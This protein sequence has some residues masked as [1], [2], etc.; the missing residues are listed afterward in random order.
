MILVSSHGCEWAARNVA[1]HLEPLGA[2]NVNSPAPCDLRVLVGYYFRNNEG[3][4]RA[5]ILSA[6]KAVV[7]WVGT[8]ILWLEEDCGRARRE[9]VAWLNAH[10]AEHW[11]EWDVSAERLKRAGLQRVRIVAMPTRNL[12]EPMPL[13]A[14]FTAGVYCYDSRAAFYGWPA[15]EKA[16][17]L[18]PDID[19]IVY[20]RNKPGRAARNVEFVGRVDQDRMGELYARMSVHVRIVHADGMPQGPMEAAMCGRP[21]VYNFR[22]MPH[23]R[24]LRPANGEG[25]ANLLREIRAEQERGNGYNLE[26]SRFWRECNDP[27]KLRREIRRAQGG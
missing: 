2:K 8:D 23:V 21:V 24:L 14:R 5:E 20:P 3:V 7:W 4:Q 12:Y 17:A 22:P 1:R 11:A 15:V 19:W 26:G 10:A 13:P 16:I 27:E 9:R 6:R 25:L 18:C